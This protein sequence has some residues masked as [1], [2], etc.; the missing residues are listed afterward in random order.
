MSKKS[1]FAVWG[2]ILAVGGYIAGILTAPKSGKETRQDI[3]DTAVKTKKEAE[4]KLKELH[5]ELDDVVARS[6]GIAK[7]ISA[8][9][10]E[11]FD[12]VMDGA[13]K[14]RTKAREVLSAVHE[15]EAADKD[16][17]KAIDEVSQAI[18]HVKTYIKK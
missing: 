8:E 2:A 1:N 18:S 17:K 3:T 16:L 10:R 11:E 4:A 12:R 9:G 6:K 5:G 15:G 7:T 14:A 13:Q